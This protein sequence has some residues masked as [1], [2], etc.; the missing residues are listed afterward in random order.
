MY[1]CMYVCMY[2]LTFRFLISQVTAFAADISTM[3][4][5]KGS[6]IFLPIL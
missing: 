1:V 5:A 4:F 2:V 6:P 3:S